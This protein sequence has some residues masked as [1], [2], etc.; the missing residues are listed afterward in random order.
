MFYFRDR[1]GEGVEFQEQDSIGEDLQS[2]HATSK[3]LKSQLLATSAV[4]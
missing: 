3:P 2:V 1:V 4:K